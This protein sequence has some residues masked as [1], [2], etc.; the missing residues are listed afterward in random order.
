MLKA[1]KVRFRFLRAFFAVAFIGNAAAQFANE[2]W[3]SFVVAFATITFVV[4]AIR[5]ANCGKSPY[6]KWMGTSRIGIPVPELKCSKCGQHLFE[7]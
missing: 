3:V 1:A 6:V 4:W 5:C 2:P 7:E